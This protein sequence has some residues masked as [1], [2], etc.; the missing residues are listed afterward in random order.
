MID[1]VPLIAYR[2]EVE[3][4]STT[5][6]GL[7]SGTGFAIL[8]FAGMA[9]ASPWASP[10]RPV[11]WL[12][13][14]GASAIGGLFFG[15][16][17]P[18]SFKRKL[19]RTT[20]AVYSGNP[21]YTTSPPDER[22]TH[23]LPANLGRGRIAV[24]GVLY[25]A[26]GFATFVPHRFNLP[27]HR[28]PMAIADGSGCQLRLVPNPRPFLSPARLAH[29]TAIQATSQLG[30]WVFHVPRPVDVLGHLQTLLATSSG[31]HA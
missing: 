19:L 3:A 24:G 30:S 2:E 27:R 23:R 13:L 4:I 29:G 21:P 7:R 16:R 5:R 10:G 11:P 12:L 9:L 26:Y 14:A 6:L 20:D 31:G 15:V 1:L 8:F 25:L 22:F 18:R 17:F 28:H